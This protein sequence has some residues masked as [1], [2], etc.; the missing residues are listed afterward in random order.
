MTNE[1]KH[2]TDIRSNPP[3]PRV[4]QLD[5]VMHDGDCSARAWS[6]GKFLA[7]IQQHRTGILAH[8]GRKLPIITDE[9][10]QL[11]FRFGGGNI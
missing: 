7:N 11:V 5:Q 4:T 10:Q 2:K 1:A 3:S 6:E 9:P 8:E